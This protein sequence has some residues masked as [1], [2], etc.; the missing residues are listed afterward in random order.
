MPI[1][2]Y[3]GGKDGGDSYRMRRGLELL[4]A[5]GEYDDIDVI[6]MDA[7]KTPTTEIL[8]TIGTPGLFSPKR[9]VVLDG[10]GVK[11][12]KSSAETEDTESEPA[13]PAD[14]GPALKIEELA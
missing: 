4:R 7:R 2:I 10:V 9:L 5:K 1:V 13:E 14:T 11:P 3:Y 8:M 12:R 6:R